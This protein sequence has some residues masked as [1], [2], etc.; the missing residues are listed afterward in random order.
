M[1]DEIT[2]QHKVS[3]PWDKNEQFQRFVEAT[4]D[5]VTVVDPRGRLL[6]VNPAAEQIFGVSPEECVNLSA[7]EFILPEDQARTRKA[8]KAWLESTDSLSFSFENRQVS[9]TGEVRYM[10]W[11]VTRQEDASGALSCLT[12]CARD[13]TS[14]KQ[15]EQE[16][17]E[18]RVRLRAVLDGTLDPLVTIDSY[19]ILQHASQSCLTC[20]GYEPDELVGRNISILMPEPYKSEH[21]DYLARYRE[22]GQTNILGRTREFPVV[23]KDGTVIECEV[24]ISRIEVPGQQDALYCGSFREITARKE[25]ERALVESERRLRAIFDGE[26]Q[27]VGLLAPD[28]RML[29]VNRSAIESTGANRESVLGKPFWETYWWSYSPEAMERI[30]LAVEA[31]AAGE[32]VRFDV[33]IRGRENERLTVDFSLKPIKDEEGNVVLLIPES[34]DITEIKRAQL[35]EKAMMRAFADI[36]ESA[37]I[38]A[39]EIKNPITAINV[40]LRAVS[41]QLGEDDQVVLRDLVD[42]MKNLESLMRRT[43]SFARPLDLRPTECEVR[44]ILENSVQTMRPHMESEDVEFEIQ[45]APDCPSI[46][47]D[48][49]LIEEVLTN[50]IRNALDA[51]ESGGRIRLEAHAA[52]DRVVIR[53]DDDGPGIPESVRSTLFK[54]FT[55]TKATGTGL[56]LAIARKVVE[57][58]DGTIDVHDSPLGGARFELSLPVRG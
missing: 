49:Q 41:K 24:S 27:F 47:V 3:R 21:D 9:R 35:R 40:A 31:A 29:E 33:E 38:L 55:S 20:L 36:G 46:R 1:A 56:G 18:S 26:Y 2:S 4:D 19:G 7:W 25:A 48:P 52:A 15:F 37:S 54:A 10:L 42:R 30:R 34:R 17:V 16:L 28:G 8:F 44:T 51:M 5:L 58:H 39:H 22:T 11:T 12:S 32:F 45:V 23:R 6:Y 13:I 43:L 14:A 53:V 57:A 50:L